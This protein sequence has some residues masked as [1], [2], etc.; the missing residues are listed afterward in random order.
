MPADDCMTQLRHGLRL[1]VGVA[2][3]AAR[4]ATAND[5]VVFSGRQHS[6]DTRPVRRVLVQALPARYFSP[7]NGWL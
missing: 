5:G 1:A 7:T 6:E 3:E 2:V 4:A